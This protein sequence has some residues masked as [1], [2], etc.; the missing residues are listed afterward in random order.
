MSDSVQ[1]TNDYAGRTELTHAIIHKD[2]DLALKLLKYSTDPNHTDYAG[3]SDLF[4]ADQ[5]SELEVVK[6][7]L[8]RGADPDGK[9]GRALPLLAAMFSAQK[10]SH[11]KDFDSYERAFEMVKALLEAGAD[12]DLSQSGRATARQN[13]KY[14]VPGP[15]ADYMKAY[16]K[17]NH[18]KEGV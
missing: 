10:Y 17:C 1:L 12:P 3:Y 4:F 9:P 15:I 16:P 11:R 13:A 8:R 5:S 2:T 6:E 18:P 14:L 7:L